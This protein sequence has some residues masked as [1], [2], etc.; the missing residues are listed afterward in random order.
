MPAPAPGPDRDALTTAQGLT[1]ALEAM[2]GQLKAVNDRQDRT[3]KI[4][5]G[6]VVSIC[7]DLLITAG[8]GYNTVQVNDAQAAS[9]AS[10]IS[11][12]QQAN[13]NRVQ[14]IAIWNRFLGDIAPAA[15]QTPKVKAELAE[16]NKL[17][18]VKDTPRQCQKLYA[19]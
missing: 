19:K 17:I 10:E 5:A 11:A 4:V 1:A 3:R 12:C 2:A 15:A 7:L 6:L 9:H 13:V 18:A 14:D 16:I 8:F